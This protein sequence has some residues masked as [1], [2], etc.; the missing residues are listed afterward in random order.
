MA[1]I[2]IY[3]GRH[4]CT[5]PRPQK[6]AEALAAAG[7]EVTVHGVSY[8]PIYASRDQQLAAGKR[9]R[10][11]P[12]ADF[13]SHA[14]GRRLAWLACRL[15]HRAAKSWFE[16]SGRVTA[17]VWGYANRAL[18]RH[19]AR[20]PADLTIVHAEGG[21]WFG[22]RMQ[23]D[24]ARVGVDFED[25][26]SRD[27]TPAQQ[28]GRPVAVLAALEEE[29]LRHCHYR[30]T[31]SR[32]L[33]AGLAGAYGVSAPAV[34]YNTFPSGLPPPSPAS[35][36]TVSL[37]WFSLVLGPER[38]LETLA[39][40]LPHL[41]G[42]WRL[43]LRGETSPGYRQQWLGLVP[44]ALR[45]RIQ[46]LPTVP[47]G[48]LPARLAEHDIGLA[49]DVSAIPSRNLT[50]TNKLF[51]YLQAGLA[52]AASDTAGHREALDI[53]PDAGQLF[54]AGDATGLARV[55]N[56]WL[57]DRTSLRATRHGARAAFERHFAHERQ[58]HLYAELA[59][60]ALAR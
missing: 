27:L 15:R 50:I 8:D 33:A 5:A 24:G 53:A 17:D 21:L 23:E 32:S 4:L 22:R 58:Q 51:H 19:A 44:A 7:H 12:V 41:L 35:R 2:A 14:P 60:R 45:P 13:S 49:L 42:D 11:E 56:R 36:P 29:L 40:A 28:R 43:L 46:F 31:T 26:F 9:W 18:A 10:W 25:W 3:I 20:R 34:A 16:R 1:R 54:P 47:A 39:A 37:H 48:E 57:A 52:V 38:G 6:E 59:D 30:L 55:L